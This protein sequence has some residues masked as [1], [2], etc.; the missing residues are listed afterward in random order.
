M[1][2]AKDLRKERTVWVRYGN[3]KGPEDGKNSLGKVRLVQ[4]TWGRTERLL[5]VLADEEFASE[6]WAK[7]D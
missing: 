5:E 6:E 1:A 4:R 7:N 2:I 3:C